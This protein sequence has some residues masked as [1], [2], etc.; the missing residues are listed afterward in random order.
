MKK[1]IIVVVC[2]LVFGIIWFNLKPHESIAPTTTETESTQKTEETATPTNDHDMTPE[3]HA[4][5]M[6]DMGT[7]AGM[8]L[9]IPDMPVSTTENT[10]G[11][12]MFMVHGK[13]FNYDVTEI[14][15]KKGD[16]VTIHF[17]ST[18]GFHDIVIDEFN[19]RSAK[20]NTGGSTSLTFTAD[21][22]GTFEYY[23][24]VGSHR[25]N[26]MVGKLIVE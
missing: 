25:A 2:V 23:C 8:E 22:L 13:N 21:K 1:I 24:S 16:V 14:R 19:A 7:D 11:E 18:G 5:M 20:I 4:A 3:E 12:K 17:M 9:P 6:G 15:V 26:G 10:D